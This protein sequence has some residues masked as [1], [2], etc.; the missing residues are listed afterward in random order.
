M[1][2]PSPSCSFFM[3]GGLIRVLVCW[4][5]SYT[6]A[7]IAHASAALRARARPLAAVAVL[8]GGAHK[9]LTENIAHPRA[10]QIKANGAGNMGSH[11]IPSL[12][13]LHATYSP[14]G[15]EFA[16]DCVFVF[17]CFVAGMKNAPACYCRKLRP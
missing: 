15:D 12:P 11:F 7:L 16:R 2:T 4:R 5:R 6:P 1:Y 17:D 8:H 14:R 3:R 9:R 13:L 10:P